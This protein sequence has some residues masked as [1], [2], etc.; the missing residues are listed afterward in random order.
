MNP[1]FRDPARQ[2]VSPD[3]QRRRA[4]V[5]GGELLQRWAASAAWLLKAGGVLT[6][7]WQADGLNAVKAA[8]A[9]SFGAIAV[10]PVHPRPDKPAIRVLVRAV[11]GASDAAVECPRLDLNDMQGRPSAAAELLLRGGETLSLADA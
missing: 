6:L 3:P 2:N 5:G 4:H 10:L 11:K 9:P 8:L 7:I 1:P